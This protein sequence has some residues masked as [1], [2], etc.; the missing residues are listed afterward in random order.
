MGDFG[1]ITL[2]RKVDDAP[3]A[4]A[5]L[6]STQRDR[7]LRRARKDERGSVLVIVAVGVPTFIVLAALALD[8]GNWYAHKRE[9]Q[10]RVDAAAFAAGRRLRLQ[11]PACTTTQTASDEIGDAPSSTRAQSRQPVHSTPRGDLAT[12][13]GQPGRAEPVRAAP[14]GDLTYPARHGTDLDGR[15]REEDA[16]RACSAVSASIPSITANARVAVMQLQ[17]MTGFRPLAIANPGYTTGECAWAHSATSNG[18]TVG[19]RRAAR[20]GSDGHWRATTDVARSASR[21]FVSARSSETARTRRCRRITYDNV[22]FIGTYDQSGGGRAA[23]PGDPL[24][25]PLAGGCTG[26]MSAVT[27]P[28]AAASS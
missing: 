6:A 10:N 17:S 5:V 11:L 18:N 15:A 27:S 22:G 16:S 4:G 2:A 23:V 13:H 8:F 3:R 28:A 7:M 24:L 1:T 25:A 21:T 19:P 9:V 14:T 20:T 12:V 26:C